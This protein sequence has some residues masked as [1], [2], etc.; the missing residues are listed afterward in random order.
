VGETR[1]QDVGYSCPGRFDQEL[2]LALTFGIETGIDSHWKS[3]V[4]MT[5]YVKGHVEVRVIEQA[6]RSPDNLRRVTIPR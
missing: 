5:A 1:L 3:L 2:E 6:R 4:C